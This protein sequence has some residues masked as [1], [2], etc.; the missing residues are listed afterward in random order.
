MN[1]FDELLELTIQYLKG[2]ASTKEF[3]GR[4]EYFFNFELSKTETSASELQR[5]EALFDVVTWFSPDPE[6]VEAT[7]GYVGE[8]AVRTAAMEFTGIQD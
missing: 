5:A 4:Y 7:M 8:K 2:A 3:C 6:E 1:N